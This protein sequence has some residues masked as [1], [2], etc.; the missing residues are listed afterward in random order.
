MYE[1][2]EPVKPRS[3]TPRESGLIAWYKKARIENRFPA[4]PF[5]LAPMA[6]VHVPERFY[7]MLDFEASHGCAETLRAMRN[8]LVYD[9]EMLHWAVEGKDFENEKIP[10]LFEDGPAC[11]EQED[12]PETVQRV[13]VLFE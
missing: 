3:W 6:F 1:E 13:P 8:A 2:T 9:L 12:I 7:D 5:K 11:I 10:V 4:Q